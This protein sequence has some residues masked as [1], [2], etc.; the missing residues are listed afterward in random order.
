MCHPYGNVQ[1]EMISSGPKLEGVQPA[2][3]QVS[4]LRECIK[5]FF[6]LLCPKDE[7]ESESYSFLDILYN[8]I[9][10]NCNIHDFFVRSFVK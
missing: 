10:Y 8:K 6:D 1:T 2:I 4:V 5:P 7:E 3:V 9:R